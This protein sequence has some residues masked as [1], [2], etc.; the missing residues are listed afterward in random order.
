MQKKVCLTFLFLVFFGCLFVCCCLLT[1]SLFSVQKWR[2]SHCHGWNIESEVL[3]CKHCG[4]FDA[5]TGDCHDDKVIIEGDTGL[6]V[7]CWFRRSQISLKRRN[8][9]SWMKRTA[10][11]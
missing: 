6:H 9:L 10:N 11:C 2:C 8:P 7:E 5:A 4:E 1:V 3:L